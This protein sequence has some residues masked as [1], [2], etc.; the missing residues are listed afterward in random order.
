MDEFSYIVD[1]AWLCRFVISL[2]LCSIGSFLWFQALVSGLSRT[3]HYESLTSKSIADS[4]VQRSPVSVYGHD[5]F[6]LPSMYMHI[7]GTATT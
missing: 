7:F 5:I 6:F 4:E 2:D 1:G 3:W